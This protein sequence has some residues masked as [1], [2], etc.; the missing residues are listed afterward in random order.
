MPYS[1]HASSSAQRLS[2][3]TARRVRLGVLNAVVFC[4]A[5]GG[6]RL[7]AYDIDALH[8]FALPLDAV[9]PLWPAM[10][11]IY[12]C[13]LPV[14]FACFAFIPEGA[15]LRTFSRRLM[16]ITAIAG[17]CFAVLPAINTFAL[18]ENA[19]SVSMRLLHALDRYDGR[20]NQWPSL[21][22]AY[23]CLAMTA[24][25]YLKHWQRPLAY[26]ALCLMACSAVLTH[27]HHVADALAGVALA[28]GVILC[29]RPTRPTPDVSLHYLVG[30]LLVLNTA[31]HLGVAWIGLYVALSL[32]YVAY[33]YAINDADLAR[34][35]RG[36][37]PLMRWLMLA[38]WLAGYWLT[39][40][41]QRARTH[42]RPPFAYWQPDV[43]VGR[44]LTVHETHLLP[45][46]C[47]VIDLSAELS[48]TPALRTGIYYAVP[49][50]D[51]REPPPHALERISAIMANER[52]AGRTIYLHCAMG[53]ARSVHVARTLAP[54]DELS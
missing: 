30:A 47:S 19:D 37:V 25:P 36:R 49:L 31:I 10:V 50:L 44:R 35:Q 9:V 8:R 48:E 28:V 7:H 52:A 16:C 45:E 3:S 46:S 2:D 20:G 17:L 26:G 24:V 53:I 34:K 14:L 43:L 15:P 33:A 5:Y 6:A 22:V 23:A 27:R 40:A 42:R 1:H 32:A 13:S 11:W 12:V 39:W 41:L 38:P 4:I 51:L 54:Q 21:H 29:V 18:H